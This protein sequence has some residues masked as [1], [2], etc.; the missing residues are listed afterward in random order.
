MLQGVVVNAGA[1]VA[2]PAGG[3]GGAAVANVIA[4]PKGVAI[5]PTD[6]KEVRIVGV[7]GVLAKAV[8]GCA[9]SACI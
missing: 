3:G 4:D 8:E 6:P 1:I 2:E 7:V 9:W 5:V